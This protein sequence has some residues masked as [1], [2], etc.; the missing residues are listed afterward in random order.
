L[1]GPKEFK[2]LLDSFLV[3]ATFEDRTFSHESILVVY[4]HGVILNNPFLGCPKL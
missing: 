3:E 4:S 2:V 1:H